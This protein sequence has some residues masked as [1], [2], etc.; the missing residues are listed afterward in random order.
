MTVRT[1]GKLPY[2]VA[3]LG[4][5]E[6]MRDQRILYVW[7]RP[8]ASLERLSGCRKYVNAVGGRQRLQNTVGRLT[9]YVNQRSAAEFFLRRRGHTDEIAVIRPLA[10]HNRDRDVGQNQPY[11]TPCRS[12]TTYRVRRHEPAV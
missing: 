2:T 4:A 6:V 8:Q 11:F 1:Y 9:R 12:L 5:A 10:G 3:V 7:L